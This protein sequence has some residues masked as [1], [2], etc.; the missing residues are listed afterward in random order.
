[1]GSHPIP[2]LQRTT[3]A[4][5]R[6]P[7]TRLPASVSP[8]AQGGPMA[9]RGLA[10]G[11]QAPQAPKAQRVARGAACGGVQQDQLWRE[12]LEAERRGQQRWVQN[13]SFLK[14]YDPMGN[15]KEPEKLPDHVPLFSDTVPSS[16]NR[17]VGSR[18]DTPL[19][20]SLIHMDF[21]FTEGVRKKKLEDEMQPI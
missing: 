2:G 10:G 11:C 19:G 8:A 3:S 15:K 21:F 16:T 20:Q 4:G 12:L 14:D 17:V 1:M 5:Y 13:W 18:L 9:G 7:P 6:L